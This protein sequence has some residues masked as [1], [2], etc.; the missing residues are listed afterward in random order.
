MIAKVHYQDD[1]PELLRIC[2]GQMAHFFAPGELI[3]AASSSLFPASELARYAPDKDHFLIHLIGMGDGE[4]YGE[5]KNGDYW[6][7][8]A[9]ETRHHTFVT[10]GHFFREHRNRD[11]AKEGIG[12]IKASGFH[13]QLRR[14]ETL[15]WGHVKKAE[16]E[17]EMAK[18]GKSLSFSMSARVPFDKCSCCGHKAKRVVDYC[19]HLKYDMLQYLP[20]FEKYAYAINDHPTFFDMSRVRRPADRIA[21]FLE[22]RFPGEDLQKAASRNGVITGADWAEYEGVLLP[23]DFEPE[24]NNLPFAKRALLEQLAQEEQWLDDMRQPGAAGSQKAAFV[25]DVVPCAFTEEL[26]PAE[27]TCFAQMRPGT[28]FRELAKRAAILPFNSF[29]SYIKNLSAE[30]AAEDPAVKR[31]A[32]LYLPRVFRDLLKSASCELCSLF[33]A[34]P[35]S[36]CAT[37]TACNDQVQQFMDSVEERF[38]SE[39]GPVRQ[40]VMRITITIGLPP[41]RV[42]MDKEALQKSASVDSESV[43]LA[44]SYGHYKLSA[45]LDAAQLRGQEISESTKLLITAQNRHVYR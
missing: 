8:L 20:E 45:L 6:P 42:P 25:R 4:T 1:Q 5:N 17:Y 30:E 19:D 37:D 27:L 31:A 12:V 21:H 43:A 28:F 18:A 9:C 11:A 7:K 44:H 10:H 29:A 34:D 23:P 24:E 36:A 22:Y 40:R 3:K 15:V 13:P 33:D 14:V 39:A 2:G 26:T 16:E 41:R 35:A 32:E 38:S